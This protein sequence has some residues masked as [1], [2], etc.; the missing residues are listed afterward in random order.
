MENPTVPVR[1]SQGVDRSHKWG[2]YSRKVYNKSHM[3]GLVCGKLR[4][5]HLVDINIPAGITL[6]ESDIL[7]DGNKLVITDC[8]YAAATRLRVGQ[9]VSSTTCWIE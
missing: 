5:I 8:T 9:W 6:R 7:T 2:S 3:H 1:G 4:N